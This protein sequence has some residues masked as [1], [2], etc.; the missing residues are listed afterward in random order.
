MGENKPQAKDEHDAVKATS[1]VSLLVDMQQ[2]QSWKWMNLSTFRQIS[3]ISQ[4]AA[5]T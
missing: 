1:K 3:T 4:G 5:G 2:N